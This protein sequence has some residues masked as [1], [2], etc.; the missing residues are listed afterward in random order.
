MALAPIQNLPVDLHR[1]LMWTFLREGSHAGLHALKD[2]MNDSAL[3]AGIGATYRLLWGDFENRWIRERWLTNHSHNYD[4][5]MDAGRI[6]NL[7][8]QLERALRRGWD[9]TQDYLQSRQTALAMTDHHEAITA[10]LE[11]SNNYNNNILPLREDTRRVYREFN[12]AKRLRAA[13]Q[14]VPPVHGLRVELFYEE[15]PPEPPYDA[16][17]QIFGASCVDCLRFLFVRN[18]IGVHWFSNEGSSYVWNVTKGYWGGDAALVHWMV[19]NMPW[20]HLVGSSRVNFEQPDARPRT[21]SILPLIARHQTATREWEGRVRAI[22]T[23]PLIIPEDW[24]KLWEGGENCDL[25][26]WADKAFCDTLEN[27]GIRVYPS[28]VNYD[29]SG[30]FRTM[31][32]HLIERRLDPNAQEIVRYLNQHSTHINTK[33]AFVSLVVPG[34]RNIVGPP[35]YLAIAR[36]NNY[37]AHFISRPDEYSANPIQ[38]AEILDMDG[39]ASQVL[40]GHGVMFQLTLRGLKMLRQWVQLASDGLTNDKDNWD[41]LCDILE[42]ICLATA[43]RRR[44]I[45]EDASIAI[46]AAPTRALKKRLTKTRAQDVKELKELARRMIRCVMD[47]SIRV[48]TI[49]GQPLLTLFDTPMYRGWLS[50]FYRDNGSDVKGI[51]DVTAQLEIS[52]ASTRARRATRNAPPLDLMDTSW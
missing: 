47:E 49:D 15:Y 22:L 38:W 24:R 10:L 44:T 11:A 1:Q 21:P 8:G 3:G 30:I 45:L 27:L 29:N 51:K 43:F 25:A 6:V 36:G 18:L 5:A 48:V 26:I 20:D 46:A 4:E 9:A 35:W 41:M 39:E 42:A 32:T 33:I 7:R 50:D 12:N 31:W 40:V 23:Q 34:I 13:G 14:R 37:V 2:I 19:Q 17:D 16:L 52:S 28:H